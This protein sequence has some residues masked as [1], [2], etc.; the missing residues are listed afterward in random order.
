MKGRIITEEIIADFQIHLREEEKSNATTQK[1]IRDVTAF[2]AYVNKAEITEE[3]VISFKQQLVN[4]GYAVRSV[5]SM[6]ASLNSLF[7]SS[8]GTI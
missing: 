2:K 8:A 6:L 7:L 5:N 4:D 3:T 1:Y